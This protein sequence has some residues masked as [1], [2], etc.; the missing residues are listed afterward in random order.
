MSQ[1]ESLAFHQ[2]FFGHVD[3]SELAAYGERLQSMRCAK[4]KSSLKVDGA[5]VLQQT[6]RMLKESGT[7]ASTCIARMT[8]TNYNIPRAFAP[9]LPLLQVQGLVLCRR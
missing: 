8:N 2:E 6:K 3:A 7:L 5:V 9:M 1:L 4:C